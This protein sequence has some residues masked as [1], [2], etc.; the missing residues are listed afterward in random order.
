[1]GQYNATWSFMRK[2]VAGMRSGVEE[3]QR[4]NN[5]YRYL[6]D[7]E[8]RLVRKTAFELFNISILAAI[9]FLLLG[10][11]PPKGNDPVGYKM[12]K[13][14]MLRLFGEF[15]AMYNPSEV[16]AILQSPTAAKPLLDNMLGF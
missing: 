4:W 3:T 7:N 11:E 14:M 12:T 13:Y 9:C 16:L 8:K 10:A 2:F 1:M 5:V 15:V 6:S